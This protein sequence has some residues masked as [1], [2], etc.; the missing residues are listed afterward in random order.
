MDSKINHTCPLIIKAS[1]KMNIFFLFPSWTKKGGK[2]PIR[3]ASTWK[4]FSRTL[5]TKLDLI[6]KITT[7]LQ[8]ERTKLV[9][10][11]VGFNSM[12][13]TML[14]TVNNKLKKHA[15]VSVE[16]TEACT[17]YYNFLGHE[18]IYFDALTI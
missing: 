15:T 8:T 7:I 2:Q 5:V 11:F 18:R 13:W 6:K 10:K 16:R 4:V 14:Q 1:P 17:I 9:I 3:L 12:M